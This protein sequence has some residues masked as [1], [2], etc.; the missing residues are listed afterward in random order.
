MGQRGNLVSLPVPEG[1]EYS[2]VNV[3]PL[4]SND[5]FTQVEDDLRRNYNPMFNDVG[6]KGKIL[7]EERLEQAITLL[8]WAFH[9]S[10]TL[11]EWAEKI[12]G[13]L[14]NIEGNLGIPIL[15]ASNVELRSMLIKGMEFLLAEENRKKFLEIHSA[16]TELMVKNNLD[17]GIGERSPDF[18]P[19]FY[20]CSEKT[21][22]HSRIE[23]VCQEKGS[24]YSL[25][26]KCPTCGEY[27]EIEIS[28]KDPDL[29][30]VGV[31]LSP[32]VDTRQ[33]I[34]D[35]VI[36]VAVHVGGPGETAYYAQVIP[37]A[38][39]MKIPFPI[40][41]KYPRVYFNTP[42]NENLA[43]TLKEKQYPVLHDSDLFRMLGRINRFR[44]KNQPDEMNNHL[45]KLH[46]LILQTHTSLNESLTELEKRIDE[47]S[48][49]NFDQL[50]AD[51]L[52]IERY[53]S[54]VFGQYAPDK[55]GQESSWSWIEWV[56]NSG[57]SDIFGPYQ[58]AYIPSMKN[59]AT[60]FVNFFL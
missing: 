35:T 27:I 14:L 55:L 47:A 28:S 59:G 24:N 4:P 11:G 58:R 6:G 15:P 53:L 43:Q 1:Y 36:P 38:K 9:N 49:E 18:V 21:C 50:Q 13:R 31:N 51:K 34:L 39:G 48:G 2:P 8:R 54:W 25:K 3:L 7:L 33:M 22:Y 41:V 42:W 23:L 52:E 29:H 5:W 37:I 46:D 19:F 12:I 17:P 45:L 10:R 44:K 20:E 26:G 30:E 16:A 56:L 40:F 60:L 57:F 32:R